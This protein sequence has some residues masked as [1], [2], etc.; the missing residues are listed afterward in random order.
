M[1]NLAIKL[2]NQSGK[3]LMENFG[4]IRFV[5]SKDNKSY[6]TNVDLESEKLII[7]SILKKYPRH[8][9]IT[10]EEGEINA[11]SDFIWHIDPLDGTH[12]YIANLPLFGVSIALAY[13]DEVKVGV[14]NMPYLKE[15]FVA[16][17]GKGAFMN[18]KRL[19][20]SKTKKLKDAF[21]VIDMYLRY[22]AKNRLDLLNKMKGK[23]QDF[24]YWGCA[25]FS[26]SRIAKGN[27]DAL[28]APDTNSWDAAAGALLVEEAHGKVTDF[29][30]DKWNAKIDSYIASNGKIHEQILKAIK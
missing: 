29:K 8:G 7:E 17:K 1:K 28:I 2:A 5:K 16:E 14:I 24:R 13:K 11:D 23:A 22:K 26:Y 9:I 12:N 10:E 18:G 4:K 6:Y 30:G 25:V 20:V 27:I 15:F 3:I 19:R 21:L